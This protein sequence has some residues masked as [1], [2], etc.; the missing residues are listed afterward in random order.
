MIG[1]MTI[2]ERV[3]E[4]QK[5]TDT[6]Q[7]D[8]NQMDTDF[9]FYNIIILEM[10]DPFTIY[11]LCKEKERDNALIASLLVNLAD[12]FYC[13]VFLED[14]SREEEHL[15]TTGASDAQVKEFQKIRELFGV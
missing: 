4:I 13:N 5:L 7:W 6:L 3:E 10:S 14:L 15:L 12:L 11:V 1:Y 8:I 2:K 9:R